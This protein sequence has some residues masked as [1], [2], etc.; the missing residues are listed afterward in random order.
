MSDRKNS[1]I[2]NSIQTKKMIENSSEPLR[3]QTHPRSFRSLVNNAFQNQ[4][5]GFTVLVPIKKFNSI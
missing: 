1:I 2:V 5:L 3:E 4:S